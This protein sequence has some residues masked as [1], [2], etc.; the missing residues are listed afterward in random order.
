MALPRLL[1]TERY[2]PLA[3]LEHERS[4]RTR[5]IVHNPRACRW[6]HAE[7]LLRRE[8]TGVTTEW[9]EGV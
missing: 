3:D 6:C 8:N 4:P 7:Q 2:G 9:R 1:L 5:G